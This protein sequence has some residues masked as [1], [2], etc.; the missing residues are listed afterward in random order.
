ME[1]IDRKEE[2]MQFLLDSLPNLSNY[3]NGIVTSMPRDI[4]E[5][6]IEHINKIKPQVK[7]MLSYTKENIYKIQSLQDLRI[8]EQINEIYKLYVTAISSILD[9]IE[10]LYSYLLGNEGTDE[11]NLVIFIEKLYEGSVGII[12]LVDI[13][14][15]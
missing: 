15:D 13:L 6:S 12:K 10:N 2:L 11:E 4:E 5:M 1:N 7:E 9:G 3:I 14:T 8:D